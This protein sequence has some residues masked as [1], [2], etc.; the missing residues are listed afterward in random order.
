MVCLGNICRSPL[1]EG[2]LRHKL[3]ELQLD[4]IIVDSAGTSNYHI[5]ESPDKRSIKNAREHGIDLSSLRARQ[6]ISDDFYEFDHIYVMDRSNLANAH[7]VAPSEELKNK[8]MLIL[9]LNDDSTYDE[10]PDPYFGGP[11][12]FELVFNLLD[13]A[14]NKIIERIKADNND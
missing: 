2:I 7:A 3:N 8:V 10:V 12:G 4:N 1:A 5:G 13:N 6:L 14:C 9:S 11:D